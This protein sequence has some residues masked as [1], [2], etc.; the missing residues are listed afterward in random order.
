[1]AARAEAPARML[2]VVYATT[3][4]VFKVPQREKDEVLGAFAAHK[5]EVTDGYVSVRRG[6]SSSGRRHQ[7]IG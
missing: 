7:G 6:R 4:A 1:M 3:D 5:P 2:L